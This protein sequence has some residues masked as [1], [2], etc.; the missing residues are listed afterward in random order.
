[1]LV[2]VEEFRRYLGGYQMTSGVEQE[3]VS[4]L[5]ATQQQLETYLNR[6]VE[7]VQVR[8][9]ALADGLGNLYLSVTPVRK[10]IS[11]GVN[12]ATQ[13]TIDIQPIPYEMIPDLSLGDDAR[14][15][16]KV[17]Y[18]G[19]GA[20]FRPY[21]MNV[22]LSGYPYYIEYIAGLDG[23]KEEQIKAAIKRVAAREFIR[24]HVDT[25]GLRTGHVED[26][27]V[28]DTRTIGWTI[29]ELQGLQRYRRRIVV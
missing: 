28:G 5:L 2:S 20:R 27:E 29:G 14:L 4:I 15:I 23:T 24:N 25:A 21:G 11:Y 13:S 1:M 16:D 19:A 8:E 9:V 12:V 18:K 10:I 3:A 22:P 6:T 26:T 7:L 17:S